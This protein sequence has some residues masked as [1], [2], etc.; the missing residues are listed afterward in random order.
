MA[1]DNFS[2]WIAVILAF[3]LLGSVALV[4]LSPVLGFAWICL[5]LIFRA[6]VWIIPRFFRLVFWLFLAIPLF[7][8]GLAMGIFLIL[9]HPL[10]FLKGEL[11]FEKAV[12]TRQSH[13]A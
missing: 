7:C 10:K 4:L 5:D 6:M 13:A 9:C 2:A 12:G 8:I 11:D 1:P 3:T